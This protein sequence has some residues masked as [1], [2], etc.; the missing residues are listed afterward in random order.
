VISIYNG[1]SQAGQNSIVT[2]NKGHRDGLE[3]GHVLALYHN[4]EV[5]KSQGKQVALPD[6][7]NGL[8][9]IFRTFDKVAYGLV[10][11]TRLPVELLD[12]AQNP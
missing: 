11:Q 3:N 4:G 8:L 12:S 7:R 1:V 6:I 10:M 5:V 9:F 2:L